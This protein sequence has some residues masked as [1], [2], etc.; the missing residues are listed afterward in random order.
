[1]PI[2]TRPLNIQGD[3]GISFFEK[4]ERV[5]KVNSF[6]DEGKMVWAK[7]CGLEEEFK[8]L[9]SNFSNVKLHPDKYINDNGLLTSYKNH[10]FY[11][12]LHQHHQPPFC[13][14]NA[15]GKHHGLVYCCLAVGC[16][17]DPVT[18]SMSSKTDLTYRHFSSDCIISKDKGTWSNHTTFLI[19]L[20]NV[21]NGTVRCHALQK[22][23]TLEL[24]YITSSPHE[25]HMSDVMSALITFSKQIS[26]GK[27]ASNR[28]HPMDLCVQFAKTWAKKVDLTSF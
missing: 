27:L 7:A 22:C 11:N 17:I 28:P 1:L 4:W 15:E 26:D 10:L 14:H 16:Y 5:L 20:D 3:W 18:G 8:A 23:S 9:L 2:S 21:L 25:V 6:T 19:E 12:F 13:L 24:Y